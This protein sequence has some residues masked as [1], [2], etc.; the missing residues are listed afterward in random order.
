MA[1]GPVGALVGAAVALKNAID[2]K[3]VGG[4]QAAGRTATTW[5]TTATSTP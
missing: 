4:L 5:Q 3:V 1:A 2:Q